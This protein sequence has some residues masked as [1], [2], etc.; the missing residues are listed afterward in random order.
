MAN[1]KKPICWRV[2][3]TM[4]LVLLKQMTVRDTDIGWLVIHI[5]FTMP[6]I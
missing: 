5:L 6:N 4:S 3:L 2:M 1:K